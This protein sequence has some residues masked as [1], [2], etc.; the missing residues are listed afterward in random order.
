MSYVSQMVTAVVV[1]LWVTI[2]MGGVLASPRWGFSAVVG[3]VVIPAFYSWFMADHYFQ[4]L[5]DL[6]EEAQKV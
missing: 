6:H 1:G 3:T 5:L 2:A 4:A